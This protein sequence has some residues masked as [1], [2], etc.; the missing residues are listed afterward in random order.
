MYVKSLVFENF[1]NIRSRS[2]T[3]E[4][5]LN[6]LCGE[7]AQGK[8]NTIEAV[9]LCALGRSSRS[10]REKEMIASGKDFC[11]VCCIF[12]SRYGEGRI[13]VI[14]VRSGKKSISVNYVPITRL[15]ELMGYLNCVWFSPDELKLVKEGPQERR[16]FLDVDLCQTDKAY[17]YALVRYNKILSQRNNLLKSGS[18][19]LEMDTMLEI[20]DSQL[21][22]EGVKLVTK[23]RAFV[24]KL[25]PEAE[26]TH[27][28]LTDGKEAVSVRYVSQIEGETR[29]EMTQSFRELLKKSREKDITLKYTAVGAQRDDIRMEIGGIDVRAFGSQGQQRTSALSLKLA[30]VSVFEEMTGDKPVLL[31]DDVLSELDKGRQKRLLAMGGETQTIITTTYLNEVNLPSEYSVYNVKEGRYYER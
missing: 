24:N 3:F 23:R 7:N 15:G 14:L 20:W 5:G 29:E 26:K 10:D 30:E 2:I 11:R 19:S 12:E 18:G 27:L 6:L 4:K 31:L 13:D 1:R 16:R 28:R 25:A 22:A 17:Y 9:S 21:A 8:T